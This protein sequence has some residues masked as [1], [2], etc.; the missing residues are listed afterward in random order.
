MKLKLTYVVTGKHET[1]DPEFRTTDFRVDL[2]VPEFGFTHHVEVTA[3][4]FLN[5][6]MGDCYSGELLPTIPDATL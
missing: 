1:Y 6:G 2:F 5:I 3:E 4:E